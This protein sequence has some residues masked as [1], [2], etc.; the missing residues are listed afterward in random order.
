MQKH[1]LCEATG[2]IMILQSKKKLSHFGLQTC[3]LFFHPILVLSPPWS[4][5][6]FRHFGWCSPCWSSISG[7]HGWL[8]PPIWGF[9]LRQVQSFNSLVVHLSPLAIF[10]GIFQYKPSTL[11]GPIIDGNPH[12]N[13]GIPM[14]CWPSTGDGVYTYHRKKK[15]WWLGDGG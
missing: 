7:E 5:P 14:P 3:V 11:R 10:N 6:G 8:I 9:N 13:L 15:N 1:G 12:W 4:F 2:E